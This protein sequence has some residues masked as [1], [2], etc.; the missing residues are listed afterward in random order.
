VVTKD[1]S[2]VFSIEEHEGRRTLQSKETQSLVEDGA[3]LE[4][5]RE[6]RMPAN[7][8]DSKP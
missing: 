2:L 4:R 7:P 1:S 8:S 6:R 3:T 5:S